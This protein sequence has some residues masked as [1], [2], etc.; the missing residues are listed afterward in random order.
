MDSL[1]PF[2]PFS[3]FRISFTL[4]TMSLHNFLSFLATSSIGLFIINYMLPLFICPS[5]YIFCCFH[6]SNLP[7]MSSV[8]SQAFS[9]HYVII[10]FNCLF[11][12][13]YNCSFYIHFLQ[14]S[15]V[16]IKVQLCY[17]HHPPARR[18]RSYQ[19]SSRN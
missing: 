9:H 14:S 8:I 19:K 5:S 12:I 18:N 17:T 1:L 15:L 4:G 6:L 16:S 11:L 13:K 7:L 10:L 3:I 2:F